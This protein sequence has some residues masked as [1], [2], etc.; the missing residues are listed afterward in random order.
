M[1]TVALLTVVKIMEANYV[2][3]YSQMDKIEVIHTHTHACVRT[4]TEYYSVIKKR[5]KFYH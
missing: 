5:M 4:H 1:F 2:S 3:I